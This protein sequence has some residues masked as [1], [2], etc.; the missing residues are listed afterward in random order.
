M[1]SDP[2][3]L[4]GLRPDERFV[5]L[6]LEQ[7]TGATA[8]AEDV[9]GRQGAVDLRLSFPD[10]RTAAVEVT[11][12]A[13]AGAR[14]RDP[15]AGGRGDWPDPGRPWWT[16]VGT[17]GGRPAADALD[18]LPDA[19]SSL[20]AVP[21]VARRADKVAR[22]VGVDE[23]HLVVEVGEGGL[24]ERLVGPLA[25]PGTRLPDTDPDVPD[26]VSHV[27]LTA[28]WGGSPLV[29]WHRGHGWSAHATPRPGV[30]PT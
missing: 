15:R 13:G 4:R 26:D 2:G 20:L 25:T 28:G 12:H 27:W 17:D 21:S 14:R 30:S 8:S 22:V 24:P 5:A 1:G 10:G 6:A 16:A 7:A 11:S 19:V 29:C 23:R 3:R 18:G 9:G